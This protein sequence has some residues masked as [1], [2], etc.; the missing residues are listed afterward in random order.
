MP[1]LGQVPLV[2]AIRE[3][4]D[5]G[6]PLTGLGAGAFGQVAQAMAQQVAVHNARK[7]SD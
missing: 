5:Q 6:V 2:Q 4:A 3:A 1:L 7:G